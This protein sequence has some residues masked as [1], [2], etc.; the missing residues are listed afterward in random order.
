MLEVHDIFALRFVYLFIVWQFG[1]IL[2]LYLF[3]YFFHFILFS[4][5][6]RDYNYAYT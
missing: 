1:E 5:F 4:L 3:K 2:R 6:F